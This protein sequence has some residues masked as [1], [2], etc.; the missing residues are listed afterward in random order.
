MLHDSTATLGEIYRRKAH[1]SRTA[2]R[3]LVRLSAML[4]CVGEVLALLAGLL[5][6][7][8]E[9][10]N[11]HT[12]V[13][14]EY[15]SST[16][17]TAV[18]FGQFVGMAVFLLGLVV[19]FFALD[20]QTGA[21]GWVTRFGAVAAI[22]A[23]ALYAVLQA[24]DGVALKHAVDAWASAPAAEKTAR[25]ASAEGLRWLEW[26][27]RSYQSFMLGL[28]LSLYAVGI[29][30]TARV[31]RSIGYLMGLSGLAYL[32]QGWVIGAE[33]FSDRNMLPTLVGIIATLAWSIWLLICGW[34]MRAV[35]AVTADAPG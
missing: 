16:I 32:S 33:G 26:G 6:P 3:T 34:R 28:A 25:F 24:V 19:L 35:T 18:H 14:T 9:P 8:H 22:V 17:W 13:F 4:L 11:A 29:A 12:A 7:E 23:L 27:T 5:H 20:V 31:P 30:S 2:N 21:L 10:A 1:T 15:A